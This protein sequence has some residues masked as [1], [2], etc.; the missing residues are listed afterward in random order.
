MQT[1]VLNYRIII[2]PDKQTGTSKPGYTALCPSLGVADDG[3]TIDALYF[4]R[5]DFVHIITT[6]GDYYG[7]GIDPALFL[8][9]GVDGIPEFP[10]VYPVGNS[11]LYDFDFGIEI[12]VTNVLN[13]GGDEQLFPFD[14]LFSII[15]FVGSGSATLLLGAVFITYLIKKSRK[16]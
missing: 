2:T 13:L 10:F 8:P 6:I 16:R 1:K 12:E 7:S 14:D 11:S 4:D 15:M 3:D 5:W 9:E